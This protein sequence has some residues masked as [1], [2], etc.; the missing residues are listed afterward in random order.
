MGNEVLEIRQYFSHADSWEKRQ[1]IKIVDVHLSK[2]EKRPW[3]KNVRIQE[4][5]DLFLSEYIKPS[6]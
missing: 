2:D 1:I 3:L 4:S 6:K 5:K